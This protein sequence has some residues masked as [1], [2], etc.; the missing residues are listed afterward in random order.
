MMLVI[1]EFMSCEIEK[2]VESDSEANVPDAFVY[3]LVLFLSVDFLQKFLN[4]CFEL[5]VATGDNHGWVVSHSD[6]GVELLV[7]E[8][9]AI[10]QAV[11]NDR[12]TEDEAFVLHRDPVHTCHGARHW[13]THEFAHAGVLV[14]PWCAVC[15]AVVGFALEHD[16][17]A[18]PTA[19]WHVASF[20]ATH[21]LSEVF[22][23]AEENLDI[24]VQTA[25]AIEAGVDHD[26]VLLIVFAKHL[27]VDF[28]IAVVVHL[29]EVNI[30]QAAT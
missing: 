13:H 4:S 25:T 26:T 17:W 10:S 19:A 20:A 30:T 15:V 6:V 5:L 24:L 21:H 12:N 2:C 7:F 28:T 22:L 3:N 18:V 9:R 23:T 14:N 8:V 1:I 11:A 16:G 29:L 27:L